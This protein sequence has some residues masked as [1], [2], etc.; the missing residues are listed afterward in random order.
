MKFIIERSNLLKTLS[1][2]QSIVERR[3]TIPVLSNVRIEALGDGVSFKATDMDTEI[4]EVVDAKI[5]E[6]GATTAPAHMLYDIVRKLAD[7]AEVE[8]TYP[9]EQGQLTVNSGR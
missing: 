8:F 1:H 5:L 2:V 7:G 6:K 9:D 3:N 4:S